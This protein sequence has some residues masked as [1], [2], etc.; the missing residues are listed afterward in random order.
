MLASDMTALVRTVQQLGPCP[1]VGVHS[2]I[3]DLT[4]Q[5]GAESVAIK[6]RFQYLDYRG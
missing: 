5:R 1:C 2:V 6:L 4:S 3:M